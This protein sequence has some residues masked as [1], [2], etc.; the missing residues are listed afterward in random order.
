MLSVG[1]LSIAI[2]AIVLPLAMHPTRIW[3][4]DVLIVAAVWRLSLRPRIPTVVAVMAFGLLLGALPAIW[5]GNSSDIL[6][7]LAESAFFVVL[8]GAAFDL[9]DERFL[10]LLLFFCALVALAH[11]GAIIWRHDLSI[12]GV[13]RTS[14]NAIGYA[15][16]IGGGASLILLPSLWSW[17]CFT[18]GCFLTL[19][20]GSRGAVLCLSTVLLIYVF[21]M[22]LRLAKRVSLSACVLLVVAVG[23]GLAFDVHLS[24]LNNPARIER[25]FSLGEGSGRDTIWQDWYDAC[26]REPNG[27]GYT[28]ADQSTALGPHNCWLD[29]WLKGGWPSLIV[30]ACGC[31]YTLFALI[32]RARRGPLQAMAAGLFL[33][34]M[35]HGLV[36]AELVAGS[37][38][39]SGLSVLFSL[40]IVLR[41]GFGD[42][43]AGAR[44]L[45]KRALPEEHH[46][47]GE[48]E[49][50]KRHD[51][52]SGFP[53]KSFR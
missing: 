12:A 8:G 6:R 2:I 37:G 27:L 51:V 5:T 33:A 53:F 29:L 50:A 38:G 40:G 10:K 44:L 4:S 25:A 45:A 16:A 34:A 46:S 48:P 18:L 13:D 30:V 3:T 7:P 43:S 24:E 52:R 32:T 42:G 26:R 31:V 36:E 15:A 9:K 28:A 20:S 1:F 23:L 41:P 22:R 17:L 21:N 14:F 47:A 35:L 39:V 49:L 11:A 19:N